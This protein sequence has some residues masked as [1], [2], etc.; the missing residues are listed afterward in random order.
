MVIGNVQHQGCLLSKQDLQL[1]AISERMHQT[2]GTVLRTLLHAYT[3]QNM[4]QARDTIEDALATAMHTMHTTVA[5]TL[6]S[7]PGS[8]AFV[9]DKFMNVQLIAHWPASACLC[10]HHVNENL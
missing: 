9:Q 4:T 1:N 6:G 3:P 2:A 10:E 7:V 8:L 5:S